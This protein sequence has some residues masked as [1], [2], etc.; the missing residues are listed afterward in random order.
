MIFGAQNPLI[1]S[2]HP[3]ND[4]LDE[5]KIIDIRV[6]NFSYMAMKIRGTQDPPI[7]DTNTT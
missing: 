7:S 5:A 2:I 4:R 3:K 6:S 1:I